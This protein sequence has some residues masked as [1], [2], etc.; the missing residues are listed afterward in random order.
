MAGIRQIGATKRRT[1]NQ[2]RW[3]LKAMEDLLSSNKVFGKKGV[4]YPSIL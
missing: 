1:S 2:D 4:F 3:L